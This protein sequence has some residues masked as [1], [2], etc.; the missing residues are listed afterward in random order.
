MESRR[1]RFLNQQKN[2]SAA[3][4]MS[5]LL[6]RT[7]KMHHSCLAYTVLCLIFIH[8]FTKWKV[9]LGLSNSPLFSLHVC[10]LLVTLASVFHLCLNI[11]SCVLFHFGQNSHPRISSQRKL[12]RSTKTQIKCHFLETAALYSQGLWGNV[13]S[14]ILHRTVGDFH[15]SLFKIICSFRGYVFSTI[16]LSG[17]Q[18][19]WRHR[20]FWWLP[21]PQRL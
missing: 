5:F 21:S 15:L 9:L 11:D 6:V 14:F 17:A 13:T 20:L 2:V 4:D 16:L 18:L 3:G 10:L 12:F 1:C 8:S 19:S 7:G